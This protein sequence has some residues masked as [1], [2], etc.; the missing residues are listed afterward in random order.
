MIWKLHIGIPVKLGSARLAPFLE[1]PVTAE[2]PMMVGA[3]TVFVVTDITN[4]TEHYRDV[5]GFTVTFEYGTPTFNVCLR[6]D[7]AALHL[8][9]ASQMSRMSG[10]GGICL[11]VR[12]VDA[13]YAELAPRGARI[14][15]PPQFTDK[16]THEMESVC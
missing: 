5:L 7:E 13:A 2:N 8:L 10:N 11:F 15:K 16:Q 4:S 6:R 14:V 9:S 12:D 3:A 1:D